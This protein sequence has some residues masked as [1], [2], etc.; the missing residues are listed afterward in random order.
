METAF[1]KYE[2]SSRLRIVEICARIP[3][4]KSKTFLQSRI[5]F[6][7]ADI[8]CSVLTA[9]EKK[10]YHADNNE[11]IDAA[12][13]QLLK[14]LASAAW[15]NAALL[16]IDEGADSAP[17]KKAIS[18]DISKILER[19]FDLLSFIYPAQNILRARDNINSQSS[20]Q[21]AIAL[22]IVDL[23]LPRQLKDWL[24]FLLEHAEPAKCLGALKDGF[25]Q[26]QMSHDERLKEIILSDHSV[27]SPWTQ[28][29]ALYAVGKSGD[30]NL[31]DTVLNA[32]SS[33][34]WLIRETAVWALHRIDP[35]DFT[36]R[37]STFKRDPSPN[38]ARIASHLSDELTN[39]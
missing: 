33:P 11:D 35:Q 16:D 1:T 39:N 34:E 17:L 9:L 6:P 29:C 32:L 14:E 18:L 2:R 19:I 37:A 10:E 15:L 24:I 25:P 5:N 21:R 8:R 12:N 23:L 22:E 3:G 27:I 30:K 36:G 4:E 20:N 7:D 26:K 38:V 31:S 28:T 13:N